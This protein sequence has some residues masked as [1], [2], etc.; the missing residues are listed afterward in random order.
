[1]AG[2]R[3]SLKLDVFTARLTPLETALQWSTD[4][5]SRIA[6]LWLALAWFAIGGLDAAT[7]PH[8]SFNT[9]YLLPLCFTTWCFGRVVGLATGAT[10]VVFTLSVNGFGDGL[11]AQ[12]S[13]VPG[14]VAAWNAGMRL[15]GVAFI[16]LFVGAFRRTFERERANARIDPLTGLGNRRS[17]EIEGRRLAAACERGGLTLLCGL[18]DVDD[19]KQIN[20]RFGHANGDAVLRRLADALLRAVRPYDVTARLGGDEFAFCLVV[21]DENAAERKTAEIHEQITV[22]LTA[23]E[24]SSTCSLGATVNPDIER[25]MKIADEAM[26]RSKNVRKGQWRFVGL[27]QSA[28]DKKSNNAFDR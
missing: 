22:T 11:S 16:I 27:E 17:F 6:A 24:I 28:L 1:M 20:D 12:G 9:L 5:S 3:T 13:S 8:V 4:L 7:G 18:I 14:A 10:V 2:T 21:R 25:A 15:F 26:Y 23:M 19:F